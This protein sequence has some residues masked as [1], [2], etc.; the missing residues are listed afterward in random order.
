[1]AEDYQVYSL[2][3]LVAGLDF[4]EILIPAQIKDPRGE[5]GFDA[6]I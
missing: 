1:M 5:K 3:A 2:L 6:M 4:S